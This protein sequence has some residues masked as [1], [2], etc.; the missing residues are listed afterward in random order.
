MISIDHSQTN[1]F[2]GIPRKNSLMVPW[3]LTTSLNLGKKP[4]NQKWPYIFLKKKHA[5]SK[6]VPRKTPAYHENPPTSTG[7][8]ASA[9]SAASSSVALGDLRRQDNKEDK[10]PKETSMIH[11]S[12]RK[13]PQKG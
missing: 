5:K 6:I 13:A 10:E 4:L 2:E 12:T 11:F 3:S 8:T 9:A 1:Q 7:S